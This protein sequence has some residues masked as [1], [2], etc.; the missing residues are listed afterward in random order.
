MLGLQEILGLLAFFGA[1][2]L[3]LYALISIARREQGRA[4]ALWLV[5][6]ALTHV[7][8]AILYLAWRRFSPAQA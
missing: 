8:G 7:I 5:V 3:W 4:Q 2:L 1:T 6:V